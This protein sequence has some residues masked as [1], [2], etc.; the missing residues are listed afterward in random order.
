MHCIIEFDEAYHYAEQLRTRHPSI[1]DWLDEKGW[2]IDDAEMDVLPG[3]GEEFIIGTR[4][5]TLDNNEEIFVNVKERSYILDNEV[6]PEN[7]TSKFRVILWVDF[8][9]TKMR[10]KPWQLWEAEQERKKK[11]NGGK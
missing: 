11:E 1:A 10:L 8:D 7:P 4:T 6:D 9:L 5:P 2:R 3:T